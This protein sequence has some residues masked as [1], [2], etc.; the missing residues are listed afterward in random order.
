MTHLEN[1]AP[2]R[3]NVKNKILG[4][5]T[6]VDIIFPLSFLIFLIVIVNLLNPNFFTFT[7]IRNIFNHSSYFIILG[8]GM[9]FVITGGGIDLS[10]GSI[11]ALVSVIVAQFVL[12]FEWPIPLAILVGVALGAVLGAINGIIISGLKLPDFLVTLATMTIYR[13]FALLHS[14]GD[15]WWRFPDAYLWLGKGRIGEVPVALIIALIVSFIGLFLYYYTRFGIYTISIGGNKEAARLAGI[16]IKKNKTLHYA[17]M[18]VLCAVGGFILTGR[19]DATQATI[20]A[21][22][23]V[24]VIAAVIIGG[25]SLFGG[26]GNLIGTIIGALIL[27]VINNAVIMLRLDFWW[28][29]IFAGIVVILAI[30]IN[31]IRGGSSRTNNM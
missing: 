4:N 26:R 20:G 8:I 19:M 7:N 15:I 23:E 30:S 2:S 29:L 3:K 21:G 11:V 10:I 12:E 14:Q 5:Q 31:A 27:S 9:T 17:L 25:T 24:E 16:G 18:G 13:G 6:L 28:G 1:A 22:H